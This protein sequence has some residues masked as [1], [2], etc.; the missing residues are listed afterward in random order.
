MDDVPELMKQMPPLPVKLNDD[1]ADT[2]LLP[3]NL[4]RQ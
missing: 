1:L 3:P 2:I 4:P